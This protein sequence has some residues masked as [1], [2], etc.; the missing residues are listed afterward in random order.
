MMG[1][2]NRESMLLGGVLVLSHGLL[3]ELS[4]HTM[5]E[6]VSRVAFTAT[7]DRGGVGSSPYCGDGE[8]WCMNRT[9]VV[10]EYNRCRAL[11]QTCGGE[12]RGGD[13][14]SAQAFYLKPDFAACTRK[15][16]KENPT[17]MLDLT[18]PEFPVP[19]FSQTGRKAGSRRQVVNALGRHGRGHKNPSWGKD[20]DD[21]M[22]S[23][24]AVSVGAKLV[25][26]A[27]K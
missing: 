11:L 27:C 13:A 16:A 14:W 1:A 25:P 4:P 2:P 24:C 12:D 15:L 23:F 7:K 26:N 19:L 21:H 5:M 6:C 20:L 22:L 18:F 10:A 17:C 9:D 8:S 3:H